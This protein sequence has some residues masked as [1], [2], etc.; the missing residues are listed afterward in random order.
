MQ[1]R[2]ISVTYGRKFTTRP[3]ESADVRVSLTFTLDEEDD[4]E[5]AKA[6][7]MEECKAEVRK[8]AVKIIAERKQY[9]GA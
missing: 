5:A 2:E 7:A 1:L 8:E 3:Y 4:P 6:L 9:Q